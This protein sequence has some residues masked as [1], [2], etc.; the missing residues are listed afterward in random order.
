MLHRAC[1][2]EYRQLSHNVFDGSV[3]DTIEPMFF[4]GTNN[5]NTYNEYFITKQCIMHN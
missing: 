4:L 1:V 5:N 2:I 3:S